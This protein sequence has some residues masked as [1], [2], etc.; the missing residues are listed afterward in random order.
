ML[1]VIVPARNE[2]AVIEQCLSALAREKEDGYVDRIVV[3]D[4][5]STDATGE[6]AA[7][8]ADDVIRINGPVSRV[9][10]AG[11]ELADAR[12]LAFVDADVVVRPGW[13]RAV[14]DVVRQAAAGERDAVI[15]GATCEVPADAGWIAR[16]WFTSLASRPRQDYV[17]SGNMIVSAGLFERLGGFDETLVSGE[18]VDLCRRAGAAGGRIALTPALRAVHLEYPSTL[19][20]FFARE[21]WHGRNMLRYFSSPLRDKALLFA[22]LHLLFVAGAGLLALTSGPAGLAF[23]AAVYAAALVALVVGRVGRRSVRETLQLALL[24]SVYGFARASALAQA[25]LHRLR[26][27]D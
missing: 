9:R 13:G 7:R 6:L 26:G 10:N 18:D 25:A 4:N 2:A 14:H 27:A 17:N 3:V 19:R 15:F 21:R 23:I 22:L 5:M 12:F 8:F 16:A 24:Y 1:A 11:A 20:A